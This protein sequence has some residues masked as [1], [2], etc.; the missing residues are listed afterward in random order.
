[1]KNR[2]ILFSILILSLLGTTLA[3]EKTNIVLIRIENATGHDITD[4]FVSG[5][6]DSHQYGSVKEGEKSD[7]RVYQSAYRYAFSTFKIGDSEFRIQPIDF[8][9]ESL[10]KSGKYTYRLTISDLDTPWA[11]MELVE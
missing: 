11:G 4:V 3:C 6:E 1:M 2:S 5:P 8:V 7:Y 9:G 10:L